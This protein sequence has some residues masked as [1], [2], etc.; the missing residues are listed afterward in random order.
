MHLLR[1][2]TA[3]FLAAV[4][5]PC[6]APA[7][8]AQSAPA[9][10]KTAASADNAERI[11]RIEENVAVISVGENKPPIKLSLQ[12]VMDAYKIPGLSIAIIDDFQVVSAKGYG[13]IATGSSTPVTTKTLFQAGSISKPVAA[14]AALAMVEQGKLALDENVNV[15]LKTWKVPDNEFTQKEKVTLRRLMSHTA[16]L[17]VHGFPGYDVDASL[18]TVVQVLNG[19]KPA[20]T[21][22]VRVDIV[23]G[24]KF[25]YSGGGVTIEQLLMMDVSGKAFPAL[26]RETVLDRIG[27]ADSS[28]EQPLPATRAAATACGTSGDGKAVHGKWHI[29]PEMA[30]AGLWTTPTDLAR[31]AIEIALSRN[32]KS[33]RIL[34]QK[35]TNEM[36]TPVLEQVGL[37]FFLDKDKPGQFGHNGADHGFQAL[38]TMNANT[39][40]GL[41][42]MGNSDNFLSMGD[43]ILAAVAREFDWNYKSSPNLFGMLALIAKL[44]GAAAALQRYDEVRQ[45]NSPAEKVDEG[46][47]NGLGYQLLYSGQEQDAILVFRRNAELY[48]QSSNVYDSLGEAYMK[49][50]QKDLAIQNYEKSLHLDPKNQNALEKLKKLEETK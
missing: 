39:G 17:T 18:P 2:T 16:G 37:G 50:G 4:L 26:L 42:I 9:T 33:N 48:P 31:F 36:L 20:N 34:S 8:S 1:L 38:L 7:A 41:V 44:K 24:T 47:L 35:M 45:A 5:I 6:V 19:E 3:L 14:T 15:K 13:F 30:A 10:V 12:Q 28:Y 27:M 11:R 40:K 43:D 32:G 22:P 29:Y 23:P 49:T 21:E 25:R 46:T